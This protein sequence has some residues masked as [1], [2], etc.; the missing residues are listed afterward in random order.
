MAQNK[1]FEGGG[2]RSG[3]GGRRFKSCHSDHVFPAFQQITAETMD[4]IVDRFGPLFA[5]MSRPAP[6]RKRMCDDPLYQARVRA[7]TVAWCQ[8]RPYHEPINDECTPDFSCCVPDMFE[9]DEST[10]WD[11]YRRH[12]GAN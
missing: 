2:T 10:R 4:R 1:G 5:R 11:Y 6:K 8:G 7:Q 12:H 3:R 9:K